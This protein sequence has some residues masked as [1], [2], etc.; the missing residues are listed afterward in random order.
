MAGSRNLKL[1]SGVLRVFLGC[2]EQE[3]SLGLV[4]VFWLLH[5][6]LNCL[7]IPG[8]VG[9]QFVFLS[10]QATLSRDVWSTGWFFEGW[11]SLL[12]SVSSGAG[13]VGED[14]GFGHQDPSQPPG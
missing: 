6:L 7:V 12:C 9:S 1:L 10:C 14:R 13:V 4:T 3:R 11:V 8:F 2:E 5:R